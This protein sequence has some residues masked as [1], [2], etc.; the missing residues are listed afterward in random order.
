MQIYVVRPGDS[1]W[2]IANTYNTSVAEIVTANELPEP[3]N[4][5]VGQALVIPIEG[6]FYTVQRGDSL[7]LIGRRFGINYL[8]LARINRINPNMT[9]S[10]GL[11]LY[12]PPRAKVNAVSNAYIEPIGAQA[13]E[14]LLEDAREA[15]PTL[16]YL[17]PFSY[18]AMR[19]GTLDGVPLMGIT[20]IA[21]ENRNTMMMVITNI[22]DGMFSDSLARDIL[23][24]SAVRNLL[25]NN[26]IAEAARVGTFTDIHFDFEFMPADQ[27]A[28]YTSFISEATARLHNE[29][30]L[31]SVALAPKTSDDQPGQWYAAHDYGALGAIVDFVVIMTYEW[32]YS[33]GPP[34]PVSPIGPVEEVLRYAISEM[35]ASKILMGQNLYGYDWTLP[36]VAGGPFARAISPQFALSIARRYGVEIMYDQTAQAPFFNYTDTSGRRHIVWFED[37]R[38]VQAK[39]DLLK[40]LGLR[41]ISYWKLGL[42][43][44]QNWLLL[45]DNFNI[46]KYI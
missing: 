43:F 46:I 44:P 37:A 38:S 34:M 41:G 25:I 21:A 29:G 32:G 24:S 22:E 23:Q 12:I 35:P 27:R 18:Q 45:G 10:P 7:W 5:V 1:L 19:D 4:L 14:A 2:R 28:A 33:G 39:F 8:E 9:L 11:R 16:S 30:Y 15:A 6:N 20:E 17:A 42:P 36:Y 40:R 31:V 26:I 13:S 3:D